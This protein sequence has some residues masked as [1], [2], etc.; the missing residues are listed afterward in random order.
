MIYLVDWLYA[1]A[2]DDDFPARSRSW[3]WSGLSNN[4]VGSGA[5]PAR[6]RLCFRLVPLQPL[7]RRDT[8]HHRIA[9]MLADQ[10]QPLYRGFAQTPVDWGHFGEFN[11]SRA[12]SASASFLGSFRSIRW[13]FNSARFLISALT[14]SIKVFASGGRTLRVEPISASTLSLSFSLQPSSSQQPSA[15]Q[16]I[17]FSSQ[18]NA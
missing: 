4:L 18:V 9:A 6:Y 11:S 8:R 16:L 12:A 1:D 15:Q 14:L 2:L 5:L 17:S 13:A 10:H 3:S 7:H